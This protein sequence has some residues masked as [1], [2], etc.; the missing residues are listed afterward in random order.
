MMTHA[1]YDTKPPVIRLMTPAD[2]RIVSQIDRDAF[3]TYRRQQRQLIQPLRLRTPENMNTAVRRPYPGVVI[4][5]PPGHIVGYCFTHVWGSLGWLGTL[6]VTPSQ[7]GAGYG[8]AVTAAGIDLL[9]QA[10]CTTLALETMPESGKNLALYIRLGLEPRCLTLLC[11]GAP[12]PAAETTYVRWMAGNDDLR[13]V[14]GGLTPGLDP[15]PAARWLVT[16]HAGDTLVWYEDGQPAAFAILRGAPRRIE[17]I[18]TY[19]TIEAAAC[20]PDA[21][22]YWLRY[23]S[24]MQT[25]AI[26]QGKHGLVLPINTEQIGLLRR[27]LEAGFRVAHTRVRVMTGPP[28]GAPDAL[29]MVTLAM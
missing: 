26:Q 5:A 17:S 18:P 23:L 19:L 2:L 7:Q 4:E 28:I 22:Q 9:R 25:F 3:E 16:E 12:S 1:A 10:G 27:T 8:R 20:L 6:G 24:E 29:L 11:Q 15:T 13:A 14:A 21:A